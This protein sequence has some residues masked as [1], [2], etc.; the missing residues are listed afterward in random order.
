M[1]FFLGGWQ[2]TGLHWAFLKFSL[3]AEEDDLLLASL[4]PLRSELDKGSILC[5]CILS[6]CIL[7]ETEKLCVC[8][9]LLSLCVCIL[10]ETEKMP[11]SG[12][13]SIQA[14]REQK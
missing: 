7:E 3:L 4:A 5:V 9:F 14:K 2:A 1:H 11:W 8:V 6:V 13:T 12:L 10:E